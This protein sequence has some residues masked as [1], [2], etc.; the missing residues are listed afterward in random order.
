MNDKTTE[1]VPA[2]RDQPVAPVRSD[3]AALALQAGLDREDVQAFTRY[4]FVKSDIGLVEV[5]L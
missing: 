5:S 3:L 4:R 2:D 1:P